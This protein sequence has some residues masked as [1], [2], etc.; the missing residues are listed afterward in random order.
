MKEFENGDLHSGSK[1]GKIVE[2]PAQAK[3]IAMSESGE[4][5]MIH[6]KNKKHK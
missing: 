3:A 1:N 4:K 6:R 5:M 2:K